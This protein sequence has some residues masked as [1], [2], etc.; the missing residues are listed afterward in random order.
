ML[1]MHECRI[2]HDEFELSDYTNEDEAIYDVCP[3]CFYSGR[4]Y[5]VDEG[6]ED[7][8]ILTDEEMEEEEDF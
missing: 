2:C 1:E 4:M 7:I 6:I 8:D 5:E 3:D